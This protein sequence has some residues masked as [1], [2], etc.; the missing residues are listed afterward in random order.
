VTG[1]GVAVL[2]AAA[3]GGAAAVWVAERAAAAD[4]SPAGAELR[5][6]RV[7]EATTTAGLAALVA[8]LS[9]GLP[10]GTAV[11]LLALAITA[12]RAVR[13]G[14]TAQALVPGG[15]LG[16]AYYFLAVV[17]AA[18]V[19]VVG[20]VE[21]GW[22]GGGAAAAPRPDPSVLAR[23]SL[24]FGVPVQHHE[25]PPVVT[26]PHR[27]AVAD[28]HYGGGIAVPVERWTQDGPT[29]LLQVAHL[30]ACYAGVVVTGPGGTG[31][32]DVIVLYGRVFL[33]PPPSPGPADG[34]RPTGEDRLTDHS[35]IEITL[36]IPQP[37]STVRDLGGTGP[38]TRVP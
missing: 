5:R 25:H 35:A 33:D 34:C 13:A 19:L 3:G 24:R 8:V 20:A 31:T 15:N 23:D 6:I 17:C 11:G 16:L 12:G 21:Q 18:A 32:L 9:G 27:P 2:V 38:A 26:V 14:M 37:L 7:A 4:P 28:A 29:L 10:G 22:S 1:W 36:P 30:S